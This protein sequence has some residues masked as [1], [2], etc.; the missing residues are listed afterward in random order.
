MMGRDQR[1]DAVLTGPYGEYVNLE[2]VEEEY[3]PDCRFVL[4][5]S[6]VVQSKLLAVL[7]RGAALSVSTFHDRRFV[8][9]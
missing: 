4:R 2:Y 7:P 9:R 1:N 3:T 8:R 5:P 6:E